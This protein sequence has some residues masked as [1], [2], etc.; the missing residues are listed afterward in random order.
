MLNMDIFK[1][2]IKERC[3]ITGVS[4][5]HLCDAVGK[6]KQ[7]L[8]NVWDGKCSATSDEIS[9]FASILATTPAYLTGETDDPTPTDSPIELSATEKELLE[10]YRSVSPENQELFRNI[11]ERLK[12]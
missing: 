1:A 11:I 10:L 3:K 7:Y 2:R 6:S 12:G 9:S 4:Q 8:N 5:K